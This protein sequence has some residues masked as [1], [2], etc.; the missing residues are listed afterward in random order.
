MHASR[1]L[2][3][4]ESRSRCTRVAVWAHYGGAVAVIRPYRP[5]DR[6]AVAEI[7]VLTGAAGGDSRAKY[8]D[9][10]LLASIFA[11]PYVDHEPEL[12]FVLDDGGTAVGYVLGTADTPAFAKWFREEWLPPLARRYPPP[13]DPPTTSLDWLAG[14]LHNPER[15]LV[16]ELADYPAHLHIDLLPGHQGAGHGRALMTAFLRALGET[17]VPRVHLGMDPANTRARAFYDRMGFHEIP[18]PSLPRVMYL[19]R[20]TV[21]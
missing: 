11:L 20:D 15:M 1:G 8:P 12:A 19:G 21:V 5:E 9:P 6:A 14:V 16:P 13:P 7:C 3:A 10:D 17:G 18:V 2:D 4:G